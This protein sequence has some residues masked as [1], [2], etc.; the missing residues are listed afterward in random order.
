MEYISVEYFTTGSE[1]VRLFIMKYIGYGWK[2]LKVNIKVS[3]QDVAEIRN[4]MIPIQDYYNRKDMER[5]VKLNK[6]R[7]K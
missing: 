1:Y 5:E 7:E 6:I 3:D 4:F 2:N